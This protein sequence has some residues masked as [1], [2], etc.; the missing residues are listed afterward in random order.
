MRIN[1]SGKQEIIGKGK[2]QI[3]GFSTYVNKNEILFV[4]AGEGVCKINIETK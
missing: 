1:P 3:L 2:S 4:D